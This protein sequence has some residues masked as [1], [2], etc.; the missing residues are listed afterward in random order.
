MQCILRNRQDIIFVLC[1]FTE[2]MCDSFV[3]LSYFHVYL[4]FYLEKYKN[5]IDERVFHA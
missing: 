5:K 3:Y 4:L 1:W 2:H